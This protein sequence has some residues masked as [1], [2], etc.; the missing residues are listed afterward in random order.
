MITRVLAATVMM[1]LG[2]LAMSA[3]RLNTDPLVRLQSAQVAVGNFGQFG[4]YEQFISI[5]GE[6]RI[7]EVS[8]TL[9]GGKK[10]F[11]ATVDRIFDRTYCARGAYVSSQGM[12]YRLK[13]LLLVNDAH[14]C[15][16]LENDWDASAVLASSNPLSDESWHEESQVTQSVLFSYS[17]VKEDGDVDSVRV[18]G[19]WVIGSNPQVITLTRI[20]DALW[21]GRTI[22]YYPENAGSSDPKMKGDVT[23]FRKS[24]EPRTKTSVELGIL[25]CCLN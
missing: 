23:I 13:V 12:K 17:P 20:S 2:G 18:S 21:V 10:R 7:V 3:E 16:S 8:F 24:G 4:E 22:R 9:L 5:G 1:A 15:Y 19:S 6:A 11:A 25:S 14:K